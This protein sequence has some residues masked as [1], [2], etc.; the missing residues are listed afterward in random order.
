[1]PRDYWTDAL[2]FALSEW[3]QSGRDEGAL[4]RG[5][6]LAEAQGWLDR[7]GRDLAPEEARF[8]QAS[9]AAQE[10]EQAR[11]RRLR[12]RLFAGLS[13][14]LVIALVLLGVAWF[15][16]RQAE[17]GRLVAR[18]GLA[19]A[20]AQAVTA[21]VDG[22]LTAVRVL[23]RMPVATNAELSGTMPTFRLQ[24][25]TD[26]PAWDGIDLIDP[27]GNTLT[28]SLNTSE[29]VNLADRD[30]FK[31]A[32]AGEP[33]VS[34][35]HVDRIRG[36]VTVV[37]AAPVEFDGGQRGALLVPLS[38]TRLE[39]EI[40]GLTEQRDRHIIVV[41]GKSRAFIHPDPS[42]AR[43][44]ESMAGAPEIDAVRRGETGAVVTRTFE[45]TEQLAAYAPV[46]AHGWGVV[47]YEPTE[48]AVAT[49]RLVSQLGLLGLAIAIVVPLVWFLVHSHL[50]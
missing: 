9:L 29:I 4:L 15:Q 20:V 39:E 25:L 48:Q 10:Q 34:E 24:I 30:Y 7:R 19:T 21:Y 14:G 42:A 45:G 49:A 32:V 31:G 50:G 8:I 13:A 11:R 37:L 41:D 6:V 28:G 2:G 27:E 36:V 22:N 40:R 26:N 12:R 23:A 18:I 33:T 35:P 5:A 16:W 44:L 43:R 3:Q 47:A 46:A 38:L 17:S 1:L